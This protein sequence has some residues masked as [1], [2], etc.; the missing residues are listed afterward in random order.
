MRIYMDT[1][2]SSK[3]IHHFTSRLPWGKNSSSLHHFNPLPSP[4]H[5]LPFLLISPLISYSLIASPPLFCR[6]SFAGGHS[7][8]WRGFPLPLISCE[9]LTASETLQAPHPTVLIYSGC[10]SIM[11]SKR[12]LPP[13]H[14]HTHTQPSRLFWLMPRTP[15]GVLAGEDTWLRN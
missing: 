6:L 11:F 10:N 14:S 9:P 8:F 1:S 2:C 4:S 12:I 5:S 7:G 15:G 3:P 13:S